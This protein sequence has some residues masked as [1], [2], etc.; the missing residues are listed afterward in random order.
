[1]TFYDD[2]YPFYPLQRTSFIF[3]GA[4]LTIILVFLV[5][6]VSLLL[7]LPG[8]RGKSRLFWM[9]RIIISLFIGAVIVALNF[10]NDW[11]EARMTTKATYKSFSNAVVNAEIGLHVGL[12]GINVTLKGNPVVQFNETIDYNE[13][14]SWHD[15]I[16]EEYEEALEKGLPNPIL[17]IAEKF[18]LSSP[19]GLIFQYRYS[20]R[21]ASATLWTAFCCW[22]LANILFSMPVIRYA[23]YTMMAT[24][25]FIFFSMASFST[26]MNVPQCVFSIGTDSFQT[27]YSHSFWLALATGVLCTLIGIFVVMLDFLVPEKMKEAFSVGVDSCEDEDDSY[28]EGFLNS[29]FLD[30]VTISPVKSNLASEHL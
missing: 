21:Y 19:C 13:M 4:L 10:T 20:G 2:I 27:E 5:L 30:A 9:F 7:I 18:T 3:N 12:Y 28:K 11:A 17:Y 8:I 16:E 25:A 24:A 26:I 15:T 14:F 29:V 23:G 22:M 1:M 6:A